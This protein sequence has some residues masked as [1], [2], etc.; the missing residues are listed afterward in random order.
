MK[1]GDMELLRGTGN[2]CRGFGHAIAGLEQARPI[3]AAKFINVL[4]ERKLSTRD[5]ERLTGDLRITRRMRGKKLRVFGARKVRHARF[6]H[7]DAPS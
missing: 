6:Y 3:I 7:A 2:V 5:A 1:N 4:D